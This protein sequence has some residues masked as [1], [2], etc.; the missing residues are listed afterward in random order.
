MFL[1]YDSHQAPVLTC[2]SEE[3]TGTKRSSTTMGKAFMNPQLADTTN[4]A[5]ERILS[6]FSSKVLCSA[7]W[8]L[9]KLSH[10]PLQIIISRCWQICQISAPFLFSHLSQEEEKTFFLSKQL[11]GKRKTDWLPAVFGALYL[12][13]LQRLNLV[14]FIKRSDKGTCRFS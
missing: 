7:T 14:R 9:K 13:K 11:T 4:R 2:C 5:N 6:H 10:L 1:T 12:D 3:P 8:Q